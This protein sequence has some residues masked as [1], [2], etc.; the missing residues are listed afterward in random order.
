MREKRRSWALRGGSGTGV[1]WT[2]YGYIEGALYILLYPVFARRMHMLSVLLVIAFEGET[3]H[4][5]LDLSISLPSLAMIIH[6]VF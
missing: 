5:H 1:G 6:H 3:L 2:N 4:W